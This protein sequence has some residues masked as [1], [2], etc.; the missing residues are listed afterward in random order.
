MMRC[1]RWPA[2]IFVAVAFSAP[3]FQAVAD[4][5]KLELGKKVF[6]ELSAPPCRACHTL[7]DA[8]TVGEVGPDLDDS[9]PDA[10]LVKAVVTN[11]LGVMPPYETLTEAEIDAVA[12]YVSTVAGKTK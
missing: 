1:P 4:P 9:K 6:L 10:E 8:G 5:A 12:L 2:A 7:A 3:V 11:G